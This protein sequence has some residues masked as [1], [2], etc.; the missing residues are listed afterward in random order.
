[1]KENINNNNAEK[2]CAV[3]VSYNRKKLLIECL[4]ALLR[5]TIP[6]AAIYLIDNASTDGTP[7]LLKENGYI[8]DKQVHNL[9]KPCENEFDI[10]NFTGK[11]PI[12]FFYV[13][14][15]ENTGGAGGFYEG[16]KRAY[17][18][19][20]DW[21]WLMD[22]D[23][24]AKEDCLENLLNYKNADAGCLC[25]III[26]KDGEW[27]NYHNKIINKLIVSDVPI[28]DNLND[29]KN[30]VDIE[31]NAF[32]GPLIKS[33]IIKKVGYPIKELFIWGDDTEFTF[34]ISRIAKILL[35]KKAVIFHKDEKIKEGSVNTQSLWKEYYYFK[36]RFL[37]IRKYYPYNFAAYFYLSYKSLRRSASLFIKHKV[38]GKEFTNALRGLKDGMLGRMPKPEKPNK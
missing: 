9:T 21:L 17:E 3:V 13:R 38:Y 22:D 31:A 36:N 4:G 20:Y 33:D 19:G 24:E 5:Q 34:R 14:M 8:L 18:K 12:K 26:G 23:A 37:F 27:E 6:L 10:N 35:C 15:N 7:E 29:L 16:I 1:M 30:I 11:E 2:V 25:P 32:V 28:A